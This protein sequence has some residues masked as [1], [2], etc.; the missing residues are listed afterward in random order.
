LVYDIETL[1]VKMAEKER[2]I[3]ERKERE[4]KRKNMSDNNKQIESLNEKIETKRRKN[5][6]KKG[7]GVIKGIY[8]S[9]IASV[10]SIK[11]SD[12]MGKYNNLINEG[13]TSCRKILKKF[14]YFFNLNNIILRFTW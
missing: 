11:L 9:E 13:K 10:T 1:K 6:V 12:N 14:K 4:N 2:E 3:K 5:G 8:D 7:L